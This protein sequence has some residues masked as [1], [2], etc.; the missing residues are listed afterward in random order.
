VLR[1]D[2]LGGL[3]ITRSKAIG[4]YCG[5]D[6]NESTNCSFHD[7]AATAT[8]VGLL[9]SNGTV[10]SI[11]NSATFGQPSEWYL[12]GGVHG[13]EVRD[14]EAHLSSLGVIAGRETAFAFQRSMVKASHC[15]AWASPDAPPDS[16]PAGFHCS[17]QT[18]FTAEQCQSK[19]IFFGFFAGVKTHLEARDC[20][21]EGGMNGFTIDG[22]SAALYGC[23][24]MAKQVGVFALN[25]AD[26]SIGELSVEA[27]T[28]AEVLDKWTCIRGSRFGIECKA[29]R[30]TVD[31]TQLMDV[32]Q[33]GIRVTD[34]SEVAVSRVRIDR[35]DCGVRHQNN[36]GREC[37]L[38]D[39]V[40]CGCRVGFTAVSCD[41]I[42][43]SHCRAESSGFVGFELHNCSNLTISDG[44]A[45]AQRAGL[46]ACADSVVDVRQGSFTGE[47]Y[48]IEANK[49]RVSLSDVTICGNE[50]PVFSSGGAEVRVQRTA[51]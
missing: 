27:K 8:Q 21:N 49:C 44:F 40:T 31:A 16:Q 5:F 17:D 14:S 35:C 30:L 20:S 1:L 24:T 7:I 10:A 4:G 45:V 48:G 9:L 22:A 19:N 23:S 11:D 12:Q 41:G 46:L 37:R 15:V 36:H 42:L 47:V 2:K 43:F 34:D 18:Y 33:E 29:S 3:S 28:P 32:E 39:V 50:S 26:V 6:I 13:V 25:A 51:Q 38:R